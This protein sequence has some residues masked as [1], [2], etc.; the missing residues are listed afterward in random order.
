MCDKRAK[1]RV[2][3]DK[4][5]IRANQEVLKVEEQLKVGLL[6]SNYQEPRI[7]YMPYTCLV[8]LGARA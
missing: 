4:A 2:A 3:D 5:V 8:F 7:A 6:L 1:Q